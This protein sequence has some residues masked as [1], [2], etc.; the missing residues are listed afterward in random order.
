MPVRSAIYRRQEFFTKTG[1]LAEILAPSWR[2]CLAYPRIPVSRRISVVFRVLP[3][4][5]GIKANG[6]D[7]GASTFRIAI[8]IYHV[9]I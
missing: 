8:L 1:F 6:G 9:I 4:D 3:G 5:A 2:W 7:A